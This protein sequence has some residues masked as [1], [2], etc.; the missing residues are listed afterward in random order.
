MWN[1]FTV[2]NALSDKIGISTSAMSSVET[3]EYLAITIL[4]ECSVQGWL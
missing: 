2:K 4:M 3:W 1:I